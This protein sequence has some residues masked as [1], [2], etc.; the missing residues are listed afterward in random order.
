MK[1][2]WT[3][4]LVFTILA[5]ALGF[6]LGRITGGSSSHHGKMEHRIIKKHIGDGEHMVW[7]S[8][9]DG[10]MI[11]IE[12]DGE[13]ITLAVEALES[14]GFEGD[15]IIDGAN[16]SITRDGDEVQVEVKKEMTDGAGPQK[17][18]RVEKEVEKA[19]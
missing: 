9:D 19:D 12:E 1:G 10:E 16:I 8:E 6:V 3:Q 15:T 17:R 14:S 2:N 11:F 5:L 13:A 4:I 7:H 18:I